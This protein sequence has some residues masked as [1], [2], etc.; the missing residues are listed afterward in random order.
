MPLFDR[1]KHQELR[2]AVLIASL[3]WAALMTYD[4]FSTSKVGELDSEY[5]DMI[6]RDGTVAF[7][8]KHWAKANTEQRGKMLVSLL[9]GHQFVGKTNEDV[10]QLLGD[11]DCYIDYEEQPCYELIMGD[12]VYF[13]TFQTAYI[14][15]GPQKIM[16][17]YLFP[18]DTFASAW[19]PVL[20]LSLRLLGTL[21][22]LTG[23]V[24]SWRTVH[25]RQREE[26]QKNRVSMWTMKMLQLGYGVTLVLGGVGLFLRSAL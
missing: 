6:I 14:E 1:E 4:A 12:G 24:L 5:T 19:D 9:R 8:K 25:H 23:G 17:L 3:G 26:H 18:R 22:L 7:A 16:G 20:P 10:F 2:I 15:S 21:S 11:R 13:L